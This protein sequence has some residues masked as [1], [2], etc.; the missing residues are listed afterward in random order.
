MEFEYD[1]NKSETNKKK[2]GI[3]FEEAKRLWEDVNRLQVQAKSETES[4]YAL[5]ASYRGKLWSAFF[6]IRESRVRIIS[7]RRSGKGERRLY[8]ES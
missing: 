2:H 1:P 4:R 3:D 6:T 5:I 7:V 8:N